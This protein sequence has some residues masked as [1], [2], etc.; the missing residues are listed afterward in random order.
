MCMST[1]EWYT[2]WNSITCLPNAC[3]RVTYATA[4]S[5]AGRRSQARE[6]RAVPRLGQRDRAPG[7]AGDEVREELGACVLVLGA[8]N[9]RRARSRGAKHGLAED[10]RLRAVHQCLDDG[11]VVQRAQAL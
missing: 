3:R 11:D 1:S 9:D 4:S 2:D 5:Y 10:R 6:V 7:P 8:Q